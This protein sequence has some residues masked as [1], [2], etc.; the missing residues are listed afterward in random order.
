MKRLF[1]VLL[2]CAMSMSCCAG[3][4]AGSED[5]ARIINILKGYSAGMTTVINSGEIKIQYGASTYETASVIGVSSIEIH[6][7][8]GSYV[9][10]IYG[11][12]NNSLMARNTKSKGGTYTYRGTSGVSYYADVRISAT[13]N[14][15][16][17]VKLVTTNTA[18]AK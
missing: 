9:T 6:K 13:V 12:P 16:T 11:N 18:R 17:E 8:D 14:G 7:S 2:I 10:T 3:A 15:Q 1:T 4:F 5:E